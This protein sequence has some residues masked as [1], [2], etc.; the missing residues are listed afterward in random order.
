MRFN[1]L[2]FC[3]SGTTPR[4]DT[5]RFHR[6]LERGANA[7]VLQGTVSATRPISRFLVQHNL[8]LRNYQADRD[9]RRIQASRSMVVTRTHTSL[10]PFNYCKSGYTKWALGCKLSYRQATTEEST[11][12]GTN[13]RNWRSKDRALLLYLFL[14]LLMLWLFC[15]CSPTDK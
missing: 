15:R 7:H 13:I 6:A 5:Q 12:L 8:R 4:F 14:L 2:L 3:H 10:P 1:I 9:H 11:W